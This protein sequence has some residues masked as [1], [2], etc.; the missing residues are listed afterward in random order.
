MG[1]QDAAREP[2]QCER[3]DRMLSIVHDLR[4]PLTTLSGE[5]E[6]MGSR[7]LTITEQSESIELA[8][9][10]AARM[11]AMIT[12]LLMVLHMEEVPI[13]LRREP[14]NLFDFVATI[15]LGHARRME[16]QGVVLV[17][18]CEADAEV[19]AD[20]A[21]LRR[22]ME[23]LIDNALRYTPRAGRIA[24]QTRTGSRVEII[25]SND[26]PSIPTADRQR[27][28]D[29]FKRGANDSHGSANF[30]LGLYFCRRTI[31]AHGGAIEVVETEGWPTSFVIT[32]P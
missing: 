10:S 5:L 31:Q 3:G 18:R 26:G 17:Q 25:V 6:W 27:I 28:F 2:W 8:R 32:L 21:L 9:S 7:I 16:K 12:D 24:V 30:G 4:S 20:P 22:V 15:A 19:H 1:G 11:N 13:A 14:V 29:K 23:N